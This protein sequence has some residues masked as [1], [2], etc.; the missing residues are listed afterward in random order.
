MESNSVVLTGFAGNVSVS[1]TGGAHLI[2]NGVDVGTS[3][4]VAAGSTLRL[5]ARSPAG[6]TRARHGDY[7]FNIG[8][9]TA[10]WKVATQPFN[11][12]SSIPNLTVSGYTA[13]SAGADSGTASINIPITAAPGTGG[14]Q[15]QLALAYS[16]QGGNGL[17]GVGFGLS[18]L[19]A[20]TRSGS[21]LYLDGQKS[22]VSFG[23]GD[24]F[25][26]GGQRLL[27]AN[28]VSGGDGAEYRTE[29]ESFS[30]V[31]SH[32]VTSAGPLSWTMKTKAGLTY[33]F[34]TSSDSRIMANRSAGDTAMLSWAL[35]RLTDNVGNSM[36]F[37]YALEGAESG[38]ARIVSITYTENAAAGLSAA[39]EVAFSYEDRP[40]V[41]T[42][43]VAGAKVSLLKRLNA[44]ECRQG[45]KVS[46]R[47]ELAYQQAAY[48]GN[49]QLAQVLERGKQPDNAGDP[50]PS[51]APTVFTWQQTTA[52]PK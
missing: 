44:I 39:A 13:V 34:G 6:T 16:S 18:G 43:Y 29:P 22:G 1:V 32:G 2:V 7:T 23:P 3:A 15:P 47:Y 8:S 40:D 9:S 17:V 20:V 31:I 25:N 49:S 4:T 51:F 14:V 12:F 46:R 48:S 21:V 35:T 28:G 50:W 33:D 38:H 37:T 42:S 30:Q 10:T 36:K 26:L 45:G 27:L 11:S 41:R 19:P 52:P 24:R 5:S